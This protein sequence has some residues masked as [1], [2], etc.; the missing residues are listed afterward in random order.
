MDKEKEI[1]LTEKTIVD[2]CPNAILTEEYS[3][4]IG[5]SN[6][7]IEC[8]CFCREACIIEGMIKAGYR[9][10]DEVRKEV[11]KEMMD[12]VLDKRQNSPLPDIELMKC[13]ARKNG[14]EVG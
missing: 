3:S 12:Y 8:D 5:C 4:G 10:A 6:K 7:G 11:L 9:K 1:E 2:S 14:V 13:F